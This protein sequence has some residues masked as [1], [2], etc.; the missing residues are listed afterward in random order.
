MARPRS[1]DRDAALEQAMRLFWEH[2]YEETSIGDLTAA[3]GIAAPSLY[4]AFGDKRALF[5][6]AV[7]LYERQP[8]APIAA[9]DDE[10][11]ARGAVE[12]ILERAAVE[13]TVPDQPKGC[14]I[15]SE[16]LL[17]AHRAASDQALR[18][19]LAA[20]REAGEFPAGTDVDALAAY[21]GAVL[22]G[23]SARARDGATCDELGEIAA[24]ALRAWPVSA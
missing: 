4:A 22:A 2:G 23:M 7:E 20:S 21:V 15:T 12:R 3:M 13:Y 17:G 1:F 10:P 19:R 8:G 9:G 14:F 11:T 6:E 5:D 24:L 16:P 18:E